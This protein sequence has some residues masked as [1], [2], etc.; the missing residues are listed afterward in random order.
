MNEA[1]ACGLP[2]VVSRVVG[3]AEDLVHERVNGFLFDPGDEE[4]LAECLMQLADDLKL[5]D[6]MS[7]ASIDIIADWGCDRF[8]DGAMHTI[9][10]ADEMT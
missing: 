5:R 9:A 1:M 10:T 7:A 3:S 4:A 6:S 2:V 8:A